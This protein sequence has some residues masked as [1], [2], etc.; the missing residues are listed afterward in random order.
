MKHTIIHDDALQVVGTLGEFDYILTDPPYPT[1]G[2]S[3]MRASKSIKDAREMIDGMAQSFVMGVLRSVN[4]KTSG[5]VWL[6]CDWRQVSYF[7]SLFRGMGLP[8]Q[9]CVIWDKNSGSFGSFYHQSHEMVLFATDKMKP[10]KFMGRDLIQVPRIH[11]SRKNHPFDKPPELAMKLLQGVTPGRVL[12][13]FCGAGGLLLGAAR[14][15]FE[16]VGIDISKESC[17]MAERR[18]A[19]DIYQDEL[20]D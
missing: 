10:S 13:P 9:S 17:E 12:D 15:G 4:I 1:G 18:L 11:H 6:C 8:G 16:V 14:M 7:S 2:Q 5:A 3:S 19:T 20:L